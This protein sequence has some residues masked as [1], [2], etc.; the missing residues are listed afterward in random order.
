M[1]DEMYLFGISLPTGFMRVL[2]DGGSVLIEFAMGYSGRACRSI[3]RSSRFSERCAFSEGEAD[4]DSRHDDA[5]A[6]HHAQHDSVAMGSG[7]L[8]K[9][10]P[11]AAR[12]DGTR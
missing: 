3:P 8:S 7:L 12:V 11:F 2:F 10:R 4:E 5:D 9:D 1:P 6:H